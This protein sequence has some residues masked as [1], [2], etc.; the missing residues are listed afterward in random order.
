MGDNTLDHRDSFSD[1]A[2]MMEL[3]FELGSVYQQ[4]FY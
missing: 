2:D 1:Y 3:Y 4:K